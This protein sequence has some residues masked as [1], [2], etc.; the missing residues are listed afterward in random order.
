MSQSPLARTTRRNLP[1]FSRTPSRLSH[2]TSRSD[3]G[4]TSTSPEKPSPPTTPTPS[5]S[6][7]TSVEHVTPRRSESRSRYKST[8]TSTGVT[9]VR[10]GASPHTPVIHYSPYA[11]STPPGAL[12]KS[13]SIPFDMAASAKAARKAEEEAR[14]RDSTP[15]EP[16]QRP[17]RFVR[18]KSLWKRLLSAP[19]DVFDQAAMLY[20]LTIEEILPPSRFAN[21]ISLFLHVLQW[22]LLAPLWKSKDEPESV[23]RSTPLRNGVGGRWDRYEEDQGSKNIGLG[24]R[25][26][27]LT[28]TVILVA[29]A[30]ANS[31]YLFTKFRTYD[32]QLRS[33]DDPVKSPHA[34]PIPAPKPSSEQDVFGSSPLPDTSMGTGERRVLRWTG[35]AAVSFIKWS[36]WAIL[37]IFGHQSSSSTASNGPDDKIQS[38]RVWEPPEFCLAFFCAYPPSAP[39]LSY[40]LTLRHP[41]LTPLLHL[42]TSFLLSHLAMSFAQLVKD[43]MVLSAEVMREYDRRFVYRK[44]FSGKVDRAVQTEQAESLW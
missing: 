4:S 36:F 9:P 11:T 8:G 27:T 44:I 18:R 22:V 41:F 7:S 12:S 6:L 31:V 30:S 34:S 13:T 42:V 19:E 3:L 20:P 2:S 17:K 21:P 23:L 37:S 1:A 10:T 26:T 29:L 32:M 25:W 40:L 43:R 33:A 14:R 28:F 38:L 15:V 24:G 16:M 35:K 5:T 39:L